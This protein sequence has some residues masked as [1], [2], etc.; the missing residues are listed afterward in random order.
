ML[1]KYKKLL[2]QNYETYKSTEDRHMFKSFAGLSPIEKN[3]F[4]DAYD[5]L[6][7][8]G[9]I[10]EYCW[11]SGF[12]EYDLTPYGISFAENGYEDPQQTPVVQGDN[13]IYVQ[14]SNNS[15]SNNYNQI[16]AEIRNSD[17]PEDCKQLIESLLYDIRNPH[18]SPDKKSERIKAFIMDM[19][20]D[21]LSG[22]AIS[23]LTTLLSALFSQMPL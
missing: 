16:S 23:G 10:K 1:D 6:L 22:T 17:L 21:T 11:V 2:S 12:C 14:G 8:C 15:I 5:Y 4:K 18:I 20:S 3:E 7:D 9:Y 13:S 19:L